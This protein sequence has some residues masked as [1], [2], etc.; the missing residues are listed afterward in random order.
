VQGDLFSQPVDAVCITT[1]GFVKRSGRAVMG[2]GVAKQAADRWHD[3]DS[4]VGDL[5]QIWGDQVFLITEPGVVMENSYPDDEGEPV[6]TP[7]ALIAYPTKTEMVIVKKD[8]EN[9]LERH[10]HQVTEGSDAPG[11]MAKADIGLIVQ[12]AGH[13]AT[14]TDYYKWDRVA[15]PRPGC[16]NGGLEWVT[17]RQFIAPI[18]DDRFWVVNQ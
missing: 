18:L 8:A 14:L 2:A 9:I 11:W 17:V 6:L 3:L 1:N 16:G 12:G 13:L 15:L 10:R 7:Y 4:R 5:L